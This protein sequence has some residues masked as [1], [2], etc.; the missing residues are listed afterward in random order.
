MMTIDI[1]RVRELEKEININVIDIC[2][3]KCKFCMNH[4]DRISKRFSPAISTEHFINIVDYC[5]NGGVT[6]FCLTPKR[7]E[8][9]LDSD[10]IAKLQYLEQHELVEE[11]FF[12]TNFTTDC[13]E[14]LEFMKTSKKLGI[15]I[16]VYGHN[17]E[18][19]NKLTQD[20]TNRYWDKYI[21]NIGKL[22]ATLPELD[23][24]KI[25]LYKR[26]TADI[27]DVGIRILENN[28]I[29]FDKTELENYNVGGLLRP[30]TEFITAPHVKKHGICPSAVSGTIND[31]N[32]A[33]C[34][35]SDPKNTLII[36]SIYEYTLTELRNMAIPILNDMACDIYSGVCKVCN[37]KFY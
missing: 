37:E 26:Y 14:L 33:L 30:S 29:K 1:E 35:V 6:K 17:K 2:T 20:K 5:I 23:K 13:S 22:I 24:S 11:Y 7:G 9:T 28:G 36:G 18:S 25:K 10:Y 19:F 27:V 21:T 16:S 12:T 32:Y 31:G 3:L 15:G 4:L 34:Y 8:L